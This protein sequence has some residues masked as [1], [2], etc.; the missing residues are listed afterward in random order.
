MQQNLNRKQKFV[1]FLDLNLIVYVLFQQRADDFFY[2]TKSEEEVTE[3]ERN[4]IEDRKRAYEL[5]IKADKFNELIQM[6]QS[7]SYLN[8]HAG[9]FH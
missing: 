9:G 7:T 2:G 4:F 6:S 1:F 5:K 3:F 8:H